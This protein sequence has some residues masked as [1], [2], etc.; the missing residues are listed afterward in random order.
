MSTVET[1]YNASE[2]DE[3][4]CRKFNFFGACIKRNIWTRNGEETGTYCF[5]PFIM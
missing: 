5:E 3:Q 1:M 2:G 4:N